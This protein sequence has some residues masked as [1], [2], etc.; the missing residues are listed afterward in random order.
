MTPQSPISERRRVPRFPVRQ[1]V[2]IKSPGTSLHTWGENDPEVMVQHGTSRD[3][4]AHGIFVWVERS[5]GAG[6][7]VEVAM[8][9]PQEI[10]PQERLDL[11]CTGSVLR[12]EPER[13]G[14]KTGLAIA[15][16]SI[17]TLDRPARL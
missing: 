3:V 11:L 12:A 17:E 10:L 16:E 13:A 1:V 5:I 4:S 9:A 14:N 7:R 15:F 2:T 8:A 6:T